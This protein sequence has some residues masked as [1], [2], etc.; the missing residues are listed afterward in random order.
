MLNGAHACEIQE[1]TQSEPQRPPTASQPQ[2]ATRLSSS[3]A[4][5]ETCRYLGGI[6]VTLRECSTRLRQTLEELS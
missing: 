2:P 5:A 6:S 3:P 4:S 1:T